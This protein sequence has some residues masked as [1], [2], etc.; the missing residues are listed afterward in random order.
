MRFVCIH[1]FFFAHLEIRRAFGNFCA[2]F[3][4]VDRCVEIGRIAM[5]DV[6][7]RHAAPLAR[8]RIAAMWA[9]SAMDNAQ[10]YNADQNEL[11]ER[12]IARFTD[13]SDVSFAATAEQAWQKR[14][15]IL[16][17]RLLKR[18][19]DVKRRVIVYLKLQQYD[20]A[21]SMSAT[22]TDPDLSK[23]ACAYK[24]YFLF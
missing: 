11:A 21:L 22:S 2:S 7:A 15:P 16:A 5:A 20:K 8:Q 6:V 10:T 9:S 4:I 12:I 24:L 14:L 23:R 19:S 18:E 13:L 17:E 1:T 3:Q